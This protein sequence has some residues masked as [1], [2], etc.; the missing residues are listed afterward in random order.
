[1]A[2]WLVPF[3][4]RNHS[5]SI[6]LNFLWNDGPIFIMDNHRA[7]MWCWMNF[8]KE[9][10]QFGLFHVDRHYDALFSE[11]DYAH[12]PL[13]GLEDMDIQ[14]YL[15]CG[16]DNEF[17]AVTPVFR[18]DN[19]LGLF[20][21]RY[22]DK[23]A[24]LITA[25]HEKGNEPSCNFARCYPWDFPG[26][27]DRL[28]GEWIFNLDLDYFCSRNSSGEMEQ[29]FTDEYIFDFAKALA[30]QISKETI[31]VLTISLSP[32]CAAGWT[33]SEKIMKIVGEGLGIRFALPEK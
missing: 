30:A 9:S 6:K 33:G 31:K 16:Y 25:T 19:Y 10:E 23:I 26:T 17:F 8:V 32:E 28:N 13:D 20:I 1:M 4:G 3:E 27:L 12:V 21:E 7:A 14:D 29:I 18:W 11:K 22:R 15:S 24:T 2:E 5:T